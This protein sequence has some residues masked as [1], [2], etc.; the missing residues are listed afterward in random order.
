[1]PKRLKLI[2]NPIAG[3]GYALKILPTVVSILERRGYGVDVF[4]T[5]RRGDAEQVAAELPDEH[6]IIVAMGG[7]GTINEVAHGVLSSGRDVPLGIIPLGTANV[8][9]RELKVPLDYEQACHVIARGNMRRIDVGRDS[10]HRYFV[11][12]AGVG[13][14]A[15]VVRI[16]ES[17]R[18]GSISMLTYAV[19]ILKAFWHYDFPKFSVEVDGRPVGEGTG[20]VFI[21]N[22]R[23]YTGPL[24]IT[25][26]ARV[27][28][29]ELDVFIFRERGKLKLL[30]YAVGALFWMA[31]RF[32]DVTYVRGKE[33]RVSSLDN[34]EVAYQI[35]GDLGGTLPQKFSVV[36]L[37]LSVLVP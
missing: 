18:K 33:V 37:A 32:Y 4:K 13:F 14:D 20:S 30:K 3:G 34:K 25:N 10:R 2:L 21:S 16:I 17:N 35:D 28:D 24:I 36:P 7:D 1:M 12:M 8:L 27:D 26:Q 11:L 19:P 6:S 23:R 22:T 29:G 31:D 5:S 15:E 9:A